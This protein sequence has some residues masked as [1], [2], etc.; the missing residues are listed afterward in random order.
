MNEEKALVKK[1]SVPEEWQL[2]VPEDLEAM[3]KRVK[4]LMP[5]GHKLSDEQALAAVQHALASGLNPITDAWY[6]PGKDG[7]L[8]IGDKY[9]MMIS[10]AKSKSEYTTKYQRLTL[11]EKEEHGLDSKDIAVWVWLLRD[12]RAHLIK[13]YTEMGA[14]FKDAYDLVATRAVGVV[15]VKDRLT[16]VGKP[17][18]PPVGW[19]WPQRAEVRAL[20][21]VIRKAYGKPSP[22]ELRAL[23]WQVDGVDTVPGDWEEIPDERTPYERQLEARASAKERE[24]RAHV[25]D[26]SGPSAF[27]EM[28][29]RPPRWDPDLAVETIVEEEDPAG[30]KEPQDWDEFGEW[31]DKVGR[32]RQ[33]A[34][35]VLLDLFEGVV[36]PTFKREYYTAMQKYHDEHPLEVPPEEEDTE[37]PKDEPT[38]ESTE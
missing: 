14:S 35:D 16:K 20:K 6:W 29:G 31:V 23:S 17:K 15:T 24:A 33:V 7:Q 30:L 21:S 37:L 34:K 18:D 2:A 4:M 1:G 9:T 27:E 3:A 10:W 19:T 25:D 38:S 11:K 8:A 32:D 28:F 22:P 13:E 5:G 36:S 12:D 26:Q